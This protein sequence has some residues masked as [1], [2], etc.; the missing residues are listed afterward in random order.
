MVYV[1][2]RDFF[3]CKDLLEIEK[4][5]DL[6]FPQVES[7]YFYFSG[8]NEFKLYSIFKAH[9][10]VFKIFETNLKENQIKSNE[11]KLQIRYS[12]HI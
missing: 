2:V 8:S 6:C 11:F 9:E 1:N 4:E 5:F 3:F 10:K 12:K 7:T